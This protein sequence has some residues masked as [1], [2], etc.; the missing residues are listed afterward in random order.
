MVIPEVSLT[1]LVTRRAA[2]FQKK[3]KPLGSVYIP[4]VK[5]VSEKC[6]C[7]GNLYNVRTIFRMKHTLR[8]QNFGE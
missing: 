8:S 1:H 3:V 4:Y 6:K 5:S 7:I 2:V